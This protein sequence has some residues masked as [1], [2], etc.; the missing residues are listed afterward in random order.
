MLSL[1][2]EDKRRVAAGKV[3]GK[4]LKGRKGR[5]TRSPKG[6]GFTDLKRGRMNY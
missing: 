2:R 3:E 6:Q 4:H 1:P 5:W